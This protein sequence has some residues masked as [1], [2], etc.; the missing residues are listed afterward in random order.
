MLAAPRALLLPRVSTAN[1]HPASPA[2]ASMATNPNGPR[3]AAI[4]VG[5]GAKAFASQKVT[6]SPTTAAKA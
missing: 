6:H 2:V 1:S 3:V 4:N 5:M